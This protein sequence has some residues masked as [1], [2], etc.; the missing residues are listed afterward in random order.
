MSNLTI[1][2]RKVADLVP[3]AA[4]PR[5]HSKDQVNQLV[6]SI[7]EFGFTNPILV[8][9]DGGIIAGHGRVMA[10]KKLAMEEV[11]CI[12]LHGLTDDQK[13][14]YVIADNQLALTSGW[15]ESLLKTELEKLGAAKFEM[16]LLGFEDGELKKL[17]GGS[18]PV[19]SNVDA[20]PQLS[21]GD[22]LAKKWGVE[23][24]QLWQLGNHRLLCGDSI[25]PEDIRRV[26]QGEKATLVFTDPPYGV[27]VAA[28][29]RALNEF[30]GRGGDTGR[31]VTDI[32]DDGLSP[33]DL[34]NRLV[35]VFVNIREIVMAED[36]SV[37]VTAPQGG[38]LGLIM[39]V[40]MKE[41][42][43]P[44]RH[45]LIWNKSQPTFSMGR[46][47]YDYKH[48]PILFT[49]GKKH[50]KLMFGQHRNTVWD[51]SR[52]QKSAEHP[53]M[54]PVELVVNAIL[55]HTDPGDITFDAYD[56][57]GTSIMAAQQTGRK[58]RAIEIMPAYVAV[59]IQR[60]HDATSEKPTLI[61]D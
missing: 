5:T 3:Y 21:K 59:A 56:G 55:N 20:E 2:Y 22:E 51:I 52:P 44:V 53:T 15:D 17:L 26:M 47:D 46:L 42:G 9:E 29:N 43:L 48:E 36:C 16:A 23:Y 61:H 6:L 25:K 14:A 34:K 19:D 49:W 30:G 24:G 8:D 45:V 35:P 27:S 4:N 13:R 39:L 50:K 32:V 37:L 1:V 28:K 11:P 54:K 60:F 10:A 18:Q 38:E 57:S 41:A 12:I 33:E 40:M 58:C 7:K 31:N